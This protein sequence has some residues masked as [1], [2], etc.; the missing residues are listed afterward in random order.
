M[1]LDIDQSKDEFEDN[2]TDLEFAMRK[3]ELIH[4]IELTRRKLLGASEANRIQ[5]Q[6][7][8]IIFQQQIQTMEQ[9]RLMA[10]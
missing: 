10:G 1:M 2:I 4:Q 9:E 3:A 6:Q 7:E 5:L 8:I